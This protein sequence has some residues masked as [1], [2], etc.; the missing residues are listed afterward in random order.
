MEQRGRASDARR[1]VG[2]DIVAVGDD[3]DDE[4][5]EDAWTAPGPTWT[6]MHSLTW[7]ARLG[8]ALPRDPTFRWAMTGP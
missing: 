5:E 4:D 7:K 2:R 8:Q 6:S 1:R 3:D